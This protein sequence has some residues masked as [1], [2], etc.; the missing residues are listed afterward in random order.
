VNQ[1]L[2]P[3]PRP[4]AASS[5]VM[6]TACMIALTAALAVLANPVFAKSK[7]YR[8][9]PAQRTG[10]IACTAAGCQRIPPNCHPEQ[11]Y[12]PWG[13]PTGFDIVVCRR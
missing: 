13:T 5:P 6:K 2:L 9:A 1:P 8:H 12:T 4:A 7:A 11:G 3:E 10:Q